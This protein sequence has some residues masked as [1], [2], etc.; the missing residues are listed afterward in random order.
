[1]RAAKGLEALRPCA[2]HHGSKNNWMREQKSFKS[3]DKARIKFGKLVKPVKSTADRSPKLLYEF[4]PFVLDEAE[5]LLFR[6]DEVI[7]LRPKVFDLLLALVE[8]SGHMLS[9]DELMNMVW[10][11]AAV[12]EGSL[13]RNISTLR[14][15]LGERSDEYR[16]IETIPWRGY[17]F[18][19][20]VRK[21]ERSGGNA[22]ILEEYSAARIVISEDDES[23]ARVTPEQH[24]TKQGLSREA[25]AKGGVWW[26]S[27]AAIL[28]FC[29][30][31]GGLLSSLGVKLAVKTSRRSGSTPPAAHTGPQLLRFTA[32]GNILFGCISPD[33]KFAAYISLETAGQGIWIK[34]VASGSS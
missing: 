17:R 34:Q 22:L 5:R 11:D 3:S 18:V 26:K 7:P 30:V 21:S 14:K 4:G 24:P 19:G 12:E 10:T 6:G 29:L 8:H 25:R 28:I 15:A 2:T 9:K 20:T 27:R 23:D 33:V 13:T 32:T 16:F 31:A 1:M